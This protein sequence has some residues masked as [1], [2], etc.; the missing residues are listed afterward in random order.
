MERIGAGIKQGLAKLSTCFSV[1]A[2][3][4]L[5]ATYLASTLQVGDGFNC[6]AA[7]AAVPINFGEG[8]TA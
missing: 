7:S 3:V 8:R 2:S 1:A 5:T 6:H 4:A